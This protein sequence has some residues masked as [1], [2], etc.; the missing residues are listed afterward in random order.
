MNIFDVVPG[1]FFNI[2]TSSNKEIYYDCLKII[3]DLYSSKLGFDITKEEVIDEIL[4]YLDE[5]KE[6]LTSDEGAKITNKERANYILQKLEDCGWIQIETS[7]DYVDMINF[8][9]QALSLFEAMQKICDAEYQDEYMESSP[10]FEYKGYL[11]S[12]YSLLTNRDTREYG[13]MLKQVHRLADE[14]ISEI[15]K[16]NLRLRGYIERISRQ[17]DIKDL[18]ELLVDYKT[19]LV[20]KGYQRLKT[21]DNIDRYKNKIIDVLEELAYDEK[22]MEVIRSEYKT[23]EMGEYEANFYAMNSIN[24]IIDIFASLEELTNDIELKNK[25]YVNSTI[26][27][28]KFLLNNE[29]DVLGKLNYILKYVKE[30]NL[31]SDDVIAEKLSILFTISRQEAIK[32]ESL[33]SPKITYRDF[34]QAQAFEN[35]PNPDLKELEERFI[36]EFDLEYSED[37]VVSYVKDMLIV[38]DKLKASELF[39]TTPTEENLIRLLYILVYSS[40]SEDYRVEALDQKFEND[41]VVLTDFIIVRR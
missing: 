35:E 38:K 41:K 24:E 17:K 19:Q 26:T 39:K 15:K 25:I 36:Q 1:N 10:V 7:N 28:I 16:I 21:Y 12:I 29:T 3:Y 4:S 2:M 8:K 33:Y 23:D 11:F 22:K 20:D 5:S 30:N 40:T 13:L 32:E 27:K 34:V 9:V 14:F 37:K 31:E 6:E 18:M